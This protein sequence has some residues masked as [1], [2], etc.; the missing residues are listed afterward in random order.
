MTMAAVARELGVEALVKMSQ[1]TASEMD[2]S[3]TSPSRQQRMH[4]LGEQVLSWSGLPVVTVRPTMFLD[5]LVPLAGPGVRNR[6]RT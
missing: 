2:V 4:W 5:A 1:M 3:N 6:G